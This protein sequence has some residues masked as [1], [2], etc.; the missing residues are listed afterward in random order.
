MFLFP[1]FKLNAQSLHSLL[2]ISLCGTSSPKK[3]HKVVALLNQN[4]GMG[5][6]GGGKFLSTLAYRKHESSSDCGK[7]VKNSE[8]GDSSLDHHWPEP[9]LLIE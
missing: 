2:I 6:W 7:E 8:N 4:K 5:L 9:E 3:T 1:S